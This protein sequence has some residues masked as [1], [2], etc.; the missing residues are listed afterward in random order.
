MCFNMP[1]YSIRSVHSDQINDFFID[2]QTFFIFQLIQDSK[3]II[4]SIQNVDI[5]LQN[6]YL[7]VRLCANA[8][9]V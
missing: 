2:I 4:L 9:E 3:N 1:K 8:S 7:N 5:G 6:L